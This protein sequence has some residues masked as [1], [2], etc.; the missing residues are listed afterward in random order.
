M[1]EIA[2]GGEVAREGEWMNRVL[3]KQ[4]QDGPLGERQAMGV[5]S[6]H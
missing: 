1:T 3:R 4:R 6:C 5:L 2:I